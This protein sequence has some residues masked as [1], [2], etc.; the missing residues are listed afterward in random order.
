MGK[1]QDLNK[2]SATAAAPA[3]APDEANFELQV[4]GFKGTP[5]E[6]ERQWFEKVYTGRGDRQKQLTLRAVLMGGVLGMFMSISNLYTT[7]K[8]GWSFGVAITACVMSFV[9]WNAICAIWGGRLSQMTMLENNCMQSTATAAG[10]STGAALGTAFGALL[11][12]EGIHRPW[13]VVASFVLFAAALGVFLAIPMKRQMVNQEQLKFP[14]GIA[15]AET[16]CSLYSKGAAAMKKAY[17]LLFALVAGGLVGLLRSYGGL[18]EQLRN[19]GRPQLWLEKLQGLLFI[20]EVFQFPQWLNPIARGQMAGLAFEPSVLLIG[21]GMI[22]GL[23]VSLSMLLGSVLLY[24]VVAPQLMG[25]D[26]AHAGL[27]GYVPSFA[28]KLN[29]DF[30]PTRWALWGGTSVMVFSSLA[31]VALQ[32]RTIA[33][34]FTLFKKT[35]R[36][37]HSAA[38]DAIE[39][40]A[41]WLVAGLIPITIGMVLVQYLAFHVSLVLGFIAV[42][43]SFVASLVCCRATG[44]TDTTPIGAMGKLT[45]LLYAALPG[46]KGIASINL[47]AAGVTASAGGAAAD[48]LTDLKSGY[49]LGANPRKQFI[50][51]FVGLF[52]GMVAIVPAWF[53]MVP[54]KQALEAFNPPAAYM[55]KAVADLLTQ[56]LHMLPVTA[57]WAIVIGALVGVALPVA[58][59]LFPKAD[60]YL[61]SAMGLGLSWVMVFQNS[62]SFAIGAVLVAVWAKLSKK[63]SDHYYVPIA[64]GLIAGESLI[65]ALI[66]IGCTVAGFLGTR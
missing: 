31:T 3:P 47:M 38:M 13:Y 30:N 58:G 52:F 7:L 16:L 62:L 4:E 25:M 17:A 8:L 44:E 66:A 20:P 19:T 64:S 50:A 27:P 28:P 11:L 45:Q 22:T 42:A 32:W 40:P 29:G 61:P 21:A 59:T 6:I 51:Q 23:R 63:S 55:W 43:L 34:A 53:A 46:A 41:S 1:N 9:I 26:L 10:S 65:A 18:V 39:V 60:R 15:A 37:A 35:T 54:N 49:L 14:S 5:E 57:I 48:L 12:I 56:G 36:S 2:S 33:R 24:F